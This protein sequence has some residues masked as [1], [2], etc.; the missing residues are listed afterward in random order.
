MCA[1]IF[2]LLC[3]VAILVQ[4]TNGEC[5]LRNSYNS[6]PCGC[7]QGYIEYPLPTPWLGGTCGAG[8]ESGV[9]P[10]SDGGGF[11]VRS[12]SP[13]PPSGVS[14]LSEN[15]YAGALA[16]V[17]QVPFLGTAYL[18]GA[19]PSAGAGAVTYGC[20]YDGVRIISEESAS[21]GVLS[22]AGFSGFHGAGAPWATDLGHINGW[23]NCGCGRGLLAL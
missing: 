1:P 7:G 18:E 8:F 6:A 2:F 9:V 17:G 14:V 11:A 3:A 12:A 22:G 23:G 15:E 13:V 20:G 21:P 5:L 10:A 19:V 16:V 4:I